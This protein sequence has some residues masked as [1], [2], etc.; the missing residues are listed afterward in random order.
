MF[1]MMETPNSAN[2]L[3]VVLG[4]PVQWLINSLT[5]SILIAR[6]TLSNFY[7]TYLIYCIC[8]VFSFGII[9]LILVPIYTKNLI[10]HEPNTETGFML[11]TVTHKH[12]E[13]DC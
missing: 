8:S 13:H 1:R 11:S 5:L 6:V 3:H 10:N 4:Q 2:T 7:P 9:N 12:K